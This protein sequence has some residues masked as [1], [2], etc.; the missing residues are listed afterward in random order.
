M[1]QLWED[2]IRNRNPRQLTI[3][4]APRLS[5]PWRRAFD[6]ALKTFNQLSRS[7][8]LGLTM[9]ESTT[10]PAPDGDGGADVQFD[11]GKGDLT[12]TALGATTVVKGYSGTS[13]HGNT[14]LVSLKVGNQPGPIQRAFIFVPE[15]PMVNALMQVGRAKFNQVQREAGHGI[16]HFIAAHELIHVCGLLNSDH[17]HLGANA[18]LF[19]EQPQP[20]SG[21]FNKP[22]ED[23]ILL[24]L[25]S[26]RNVVAPPIFLKKATVDLIKANWS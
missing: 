5:K 24:H 15:T 25:T 17:T 14:Q 19:V 16:K 23:R 26:P 3:F 12:Y 18:D 1:P 4:V 13:M 11:M 2:R 7:N 8:Q 6:D 9:V 21:P 20:N 10:M 22:D